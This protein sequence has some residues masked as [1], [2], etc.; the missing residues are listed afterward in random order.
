LEK[1]AMK[2]SL[3]ALAVLAASGAA[4][5]QSSVTLFGVLDLGVESVKTNAGRV[6]GISPS[7]NSSSRLGF[8]GVED[9]GGG[10]AASFWLEA[11]LNP[12]SGIGSSGTSANNQT[13]TTAAGG[14]TFNRRSTLSL[15]G[16]FGEVRVGRDYVPTFWN[17]AIF[18]PFGANSIGATISNYSGAG[19]SATFVR[20]SNSIGYFLPNNLGGFYG[21]GMYA[22]GN[23]ASNEVTG[24]VNTSD[25]GTYT[26][27]RVGYA[28]GPI[29]AALAYAQ[30][31]FAAGT[32]AVAIAGA[33]STSGNFQDFNLGGSYDF[34]VAKAMGTISNQKLNDLGTVGNNQSV[35]GW[36]IGANAPVGAGNV[37]VQY[38]AIKLV[39]AKSDKWSFGYVYNLSKRTAVY[40]LLARV[41]NSGGAA[42]TAAS[43][44]SGS[45][46]AVAGASNVNASST[47]VSLGLR[48]SF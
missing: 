28:Q 15:S 4:M 40:G 31:K 7:A 39:S 16:N 5:A 42:S 30:T 26:G 29:D 1:L 35:K 48:T 8:K 24:G 22:F 45:L 13:T 6:T 10:L 9:L 27:F 18:D 11:A 17:Y 21:Q 2:K 36:S 34:G 33:S 38:S 12:S 25:N 19:A 43:F 46:G 23:R 14:L 47:G 37:L 32:N 41:G 44:S 3:I 20:S